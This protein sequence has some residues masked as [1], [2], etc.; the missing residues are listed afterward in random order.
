MLNAGMIGAIVGFLYLC[1][2]SFVHAYYW[3]AGWTV[4]DIP[5]LQMKLVIEGGKLLIL[6]DLLEHGPTYVLVGMTVAVLCMYIVER[7]IVWILAMKRKR[8][9]AAEQ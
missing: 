9:S 4:V 7:V 2:V 5:G 1:G 6:G 3:M 8:K